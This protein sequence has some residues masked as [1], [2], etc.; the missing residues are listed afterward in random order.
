MRVI[1]KIRANPQTE[2]EHR[3]PFAK[4]GLARFVVFKGFQQPCFA[5]PWFGLLSVS[6]RF[7]FWLPLVRCLQKSAL[8]AVTKGCQWQ[9]YCAV[10]GQN[11]APPRSSAIFIPLQIQQWFPGLQSG[12][13]L[14]PS[15]AG[16]VGTNRDELGGEK[17]S[18]SVAQLTPKRCPGS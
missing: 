6:R 14:R 17:G 1:Y 8:Q 3:E 18:V 16:L 10:D 11:P 5:S 9:Q 4:L 12:A 15:T 7:F 13:G 2:T